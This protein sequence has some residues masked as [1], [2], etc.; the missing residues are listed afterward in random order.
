MVLFKAQNLRSKHFFNCKLS[1]VVMK[2]ILYSQ[3]LPNKMSPLKMNSQSQI[4]FAMHP[5]KT[6]SETI[7]DLQISTPKINQPSIYFNQI[8]SWWHS[9]IPRY[10]QAREDTL[11]GALALSQGQFLT[12][13][14]GGAQPPADFLN[15]TTN[16]HT[17][18]NCF[19]YLKQLTTIY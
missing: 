5:H 8:G 13:T 18:L 7:T 1:H 19:I 12:L 6:S 14:I 15:P 3:I 9:R 2:L 17:K 10:F 11:Q 4:I 16:S